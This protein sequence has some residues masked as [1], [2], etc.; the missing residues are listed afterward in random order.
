M[1]K[2]LKGYY[3]H[4]KYQKNESFSNKQD[5]WYTGHLSNVQEGTF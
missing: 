2:Q 4:V 3:M 5:G 1:T